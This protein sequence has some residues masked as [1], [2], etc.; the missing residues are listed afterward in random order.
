MS[1]YVKLVTSFEHQDMARRTFIRLQ[2]RKASCVRVEILAV[3]IPSI[4]LS[5][6]NKKPHSI[7]STRSWVLVYITFAHGRTDGQIFFEKVF[8]FLQEYIYM[9]IPISIIFQI[10]PS[11]WPKLVY[12]F[13]QWKW[14]WNGEI[15]IY[16]RARPT[17]QT[18]SF[19]VNSPK[20]Y[21]SDF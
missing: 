10:S 11:F 17:Q 7:I 16:S 19:F 4:H 15:G 13:F 5:N 6:K 20:N 18:S 12:L 21:V 2:P 1:T 8:F 14:V 3:S 9:S